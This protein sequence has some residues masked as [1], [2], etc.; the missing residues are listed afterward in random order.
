[1]LKISFYIALLF[2]LILILPSVS[3]ARV[4]RIEITKCIPLAD[5]MRFENTLAV[6]GK[7]PLSLWG[8]IHGVPWSARPA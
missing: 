1:M 5:G 2:T 4:V 8:C 3:L 7:P 6:A